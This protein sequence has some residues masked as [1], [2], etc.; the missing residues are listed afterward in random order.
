V[1]LPED[2][3]ENLGWRFGYEY[4][5]EGFDSSPNKRGTYSLLPLRELG[6]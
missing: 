4:R 1:R 6:G 5:F 2:F 3:E